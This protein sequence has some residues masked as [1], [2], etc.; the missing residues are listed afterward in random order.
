MTI[1]TVAVKPVA[2]ITVTVTTVAFTTV[3]VTIMAVTTGTVTITTVTTVILYYI[4][5]NCIY[6]CFDG[7]TMN[8]PLDG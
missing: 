5:Y 2:F 6:F 7:L 3:T 1:N 8:L 4:K